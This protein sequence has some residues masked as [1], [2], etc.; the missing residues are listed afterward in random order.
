MTHGENVGKLDVELSQRLW[1]LI[2][3]YPTMRQTPRPS[4]YSCP[5]PFAHPQIRKSAEGDSQSHCTA[6]AV[7]ALQH[8]S[9]GFLRNA[10]GAMR[11]EVNAHAA[12]V[13]KP[14]L[15]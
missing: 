3:K 8:N 13:G 12:L 4:R 7:L 15:C 9:T 11:F 1:S 14:R 2:L 10:S 5:L 6:L